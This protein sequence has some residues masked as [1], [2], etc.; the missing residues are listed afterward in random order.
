MTINKY[1]HGFASPLG[2]YLTFLA[3]LVTIFCRMLA[4]RNY[5]HHVDNLKQLENNQKAS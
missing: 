2:I 5:L 4:V 1:F 3:S